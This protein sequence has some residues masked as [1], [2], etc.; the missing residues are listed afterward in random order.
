MALRLLSAHLPREGAK[1]PATSSERWNNMP[2][3]YLGIDRHLRPI[4]SSSRP[5]LNASC[6][7]NPK[8]KHNGKQIRCD[9]GL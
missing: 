6:A 5:W 1:L 9:K 2:N 7:F 4:D 3:R 8:R